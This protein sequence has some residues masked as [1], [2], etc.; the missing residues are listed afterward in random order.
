MGRFLAASIATTLSTF[1]GLAVLGA[2]DGRSDVGVGSAPPCS[3]ACQ[4]PQ[5][6]CYGGFVYY[7][8]LPDGAG[9]VL[10]YSD[11]A[12]E[13]LVT[14]TCGNLLT[15]DAGPVINAELDGGLGSCQTRN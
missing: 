12:Q 5:V 3:P 11:A 15:Y 6:C 14:S 2:C 10:T 8:A 7:T 4:A 13:F 1:L 9:P